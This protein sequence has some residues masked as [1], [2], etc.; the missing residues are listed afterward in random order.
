MVL[1]RVGGQL[2]GLYTRDG[3]DT[4]VKGELKN[5]AS[6]TLTEVVAKGKRPAVFE[7][8]IDGPNIS[9]TWTIGK[10]PQPFTAGPIDSFG[11]SV[12]FDETYLGSLGTK[13]RVR[14]KLKKAG[15]KLTGAYR[16]MKSK[17]DLMLEGTLAP[18][19][20]MSLTETTAKGVV[21][22]RFEG[23]FA[24]QELGLGRWSSPDGSKT[25]PFT[26]RH[27]DVY[28]E[29][30]AIPGGASVVPQEEHAE[31]GKFCTSSVIYPEVVGTGPNLKILNTRLKKAAGGTKL[32]FCNDAS[33]ESPNESDTTYHVEA[34]RPDRVAFSY[35]QFSYTGGAHGLYGLQCLLADLDKG[36]LTEGRAKLLAP[37]SR[38]KLQALVNAALKKEHK[39]QNLM[40]VDFTVEE[41][42]LE[43]ET[44]VCVEGT[45]LVVLFQIYTVTPYYMGT[46]TATIPAKEA[47]PLVVGTPFEPFFK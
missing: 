40:E 6:F 31:R 2:Q 26:F 20:K 28:P 45:N 17:E 8:K 13:L 18:D 34:T 5:G 43:D 32:D 10:K 1:E 36:T 41:V 23:I 19:G 42:P 21:T 3:A 15:G 35:T 16:Y 29:T 11:P 37:A 25:L 22:G 33:D 14:M 46:P 38:K 30:V 7:G 9:G 47:A 44:Y 24:E 4:P 39:V 27:A 12:T